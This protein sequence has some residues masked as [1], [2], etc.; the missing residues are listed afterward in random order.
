M[1]LRP[2]LLCPI[3]LASPGVACACS[4][5][6]CGR[7]CDVFCGY[8]SGFLLVRC[9]GRRHRLSTS[10]SLFAGRLLS[11]DVPT[12]RHDL[13]FS[14]GV[15]PGSFQRLQLTWVLKCECCIL[16]GAV[17]CRCSLLPVVALRRCRV[18]SVCVVRLIYRCQLLRARDHTPL[19]CG[20]VTGSSAHA[21]R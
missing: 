15:A 18:D 3:A 20:F 12:I 13:A 8:L 14:A 21:I 9:F 1:S 5:V 19:L 11:A 4:V 2:H 7:V 10:T 6:R 17:T 16:R